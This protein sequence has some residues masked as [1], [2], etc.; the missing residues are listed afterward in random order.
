MAQTIAR[1]KGQRPIIAGRL[2]PLRGD[3]RD[4]GFQAFLLLWIGFTVAPV[5]FGID[6]FFNWMTY[7]P[8]YLWAGFPHL[9]GHVP[10]QQFMYAVGVVEIAAGVLVLVLPR[11]APYVVAGWLGGII[12]NL[13]II[14]GAGRAQ[15]SLLGHRAARFRAPA[16]RP[17]ARKAGRGVRSESLP[18]GQG[19]SRCR[20]GRLRPR[21]H[22]DAA[23]GLTGPGQC[24]T[25]RPGRPAVPHPEPP[26]LRGAEWALAK[27]EGNKLR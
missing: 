9:F 15:Q 27:K 12:T 23:R 1:T 21:P 7:W 16:R 26:M 5:L 13:V 14:S 3:V 17:G 22:R 4:P 24:Q 2:G 18:P 11:F 19:P 8:K 20:A 6:K 10:P 25:G